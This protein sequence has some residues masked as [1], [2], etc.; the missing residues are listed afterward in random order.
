MGSAAPV[1]RGFL[2]RAFRRRAGGAF[3]IFRFGSAFPLAKAL[4][5]VAR[6]HNSAEAAYRR[7]PGLV[8]K[9]EQGTD[10]RL[11]KVLIAALLLADLRQNRFPVGGHIRARRHFRQRVKQRL[12]GVSGVDIAPFL[13]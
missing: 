10:Q 8:D 4:L 12:P 6:G 7:A 3:F 11:H 2:L 9:L 5:A 13:G 1:S